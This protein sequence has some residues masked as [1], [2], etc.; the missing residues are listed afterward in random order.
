[1]SKWSSKEKFL[2]KNMTYI[3]CYEV[4]DDDKFLYV[5]KKSDQTK[6][7]HCVFEGVEKECRRFILQHQLK[8]QTPSLKKISCGFIG[9]IP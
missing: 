1:M 6:S 7:E 4:F 5:R 9:Y 3:V 8:T 2:L